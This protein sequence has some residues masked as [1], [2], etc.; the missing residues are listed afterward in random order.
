[1]AIKYSVEQTFK[2]NFTTKVNKLRNSIHRVD[3][4]LQSVSCFFFHFDD[5]TGARE[6]ACDNIL[7][8]I[9]KSAASDQIGSRGCDTKCV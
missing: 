6:C 1:M 3:K 4:E 7:N 2:S 5:R 9:Q 8:F